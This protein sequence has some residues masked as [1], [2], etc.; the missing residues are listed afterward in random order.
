MFWTE[1]REGH[2]PP[3]SLHIKYH[4]YWSFMH[5]ASGCFF[6]FFF[7]VTGLFDKD[8][9]HY[10]HYSKCASVSKE[11]VFH[12]SSLGNWLLS[13]KMAAGTAGAVTAH[14]LNILSFYSCRGV[15]QAHHISLDCSPPLAIWIHL[16]YRRLKGRHS[17]DLCERE[18]TVQWNPLVWKCVGPKIILLLQMSFLIVIHHPPSPNSCFCEEFDELCGRTPK[19]D[20]CL[21][22]AW[23]PVTAAWIG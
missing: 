17:Y 9:A 20:K 5:I 1:N 22:K 13:A 7:I 15:D 18:F 11:A 2:Q 23:C 14:Q 3:N 8:C 4:S 21:A 19:L 16:Q 6:F 12:L 10:K